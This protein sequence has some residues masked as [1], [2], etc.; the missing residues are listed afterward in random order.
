M[1][2][3]PSFRP[4]AAGSNRCCAEPIGVTSEPK[5]WSPA[6]DPALCA[7]L[8]A[9]NYPSGSPEPSDND[10]QVSQ[11]LVSA[12]NT[13]QIR[14]LDHT[15]IRDNRYFTVADAGLIEEYNLHFL[16]LK[17]KRHWQRNG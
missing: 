7:V 15:I 17:G 8:C 9:H 12:A 16:S 1:V 10:K 3:A 4:P 6:A 2:T 11:D 14:V 13:I 5:G